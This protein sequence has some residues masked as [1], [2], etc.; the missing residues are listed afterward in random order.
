[1]V[2]VARAS[3]SLAL[4]A[5]LRVAAVVLPLLAL[6]AI[7]PCA[8]AATT[9]QVKNEADS[10]AG[11]LREAVAES[12]AGDTIEFAPALAGKT[13]TLTGGQIAIKHDLTIAGP[14][15]S[16]L[17]I[18]AGSASRIFDVE[19]QS[20]E[21]TAAVTISGL[22][23]TNG[24]LP[25]PPEPPESGAAIRLAKGPAGAMLTLNDDAITKN[26]DE[27]TEPTTGGGAIALESGETPSLT[28]TDST[29]SNN[30][31]G[32][33]GGAVFDE[34]TS[35]VTLARST[36]TENKAAAGGAVYVGGETAPK[37]V[38]IE[39][40]TFSA[41]EADGASGPNPS[42]GG[43]LLIEKGAVEVLN[44]T[45]ANNVAN[46]GNGGAISSCCSLAHVA[47]LVNDTI[48]GNEA[49]GSGGE[50]GNLAGEENKLSLLNTIVAEGVASTAV[51]D[52][53]ALAEQS[54]GHNLESTVDACGL[55]QPADLVD[56]DPLLGP[57]AANGGL[58][59]T[60][61]LLT[62]SPA[63]DAGSS[64]CPKTDQR[65]VSRPQGPA[66]DIGAYE[67][68]VAKSKEQP[69]QQPTKSGG[70]AS[71]VAGATAPT[72]PASTGSRARYLA[73]TLVTAPLVIKGA[74]V[75]HFKYTPKRFHTSYCVPRPAGRY[76]CDVSWRH[77]KYT[78]AGR[79]EVGNLNVYTGHY[80]YGLHIVQ[81]NP[82]TRRHRTLRIAY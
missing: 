26:S 3:A 19:V 73:L 35:P 22:T 42:G 47:A 14:G 38:L 68:E 59:D 1:M 45:L 4:G 46:G 40:S 78:F 5:A 28:V 20:A 80:R 39:A 31:A 32:G 37:L 67:L 48:A 49:I 63:I 21:T 77:G 72:S 60:M 9:I 54:R 66:C 82:R 27:N 51:T 71:V 36:F 33:H 7:A 50:G 79:V 10:G 76:R 16:Q 2:G 11:S 57:L 74:V 24:H 56:E 81:T 53:C 23:L 15:L 18:G 12:H 25:A 65:G 34:S 61:A 62:A 6:G 13:I 70:D 52:N 69:P 30:T 17:T 43:A 55:D 29:I 75:F 8:L 44:S 64:T 58:T 41:N